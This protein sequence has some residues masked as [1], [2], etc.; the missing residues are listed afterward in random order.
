MQVYVH[1]LWP[2]NQYGKYGSCT[3]E[4]FQV[5]FHCILGK[6]GVFE[7]TGRD[8]GVIRVW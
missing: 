8:M 7:T 4:L 2:I 1:N 3:P 5:N 6:M